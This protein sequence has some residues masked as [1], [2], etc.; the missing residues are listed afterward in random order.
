MGRPTGDSAGFNLDFT[1]SQTRFETKAKEARLRHCA[2][3]WRTLPR[4]ESRPSVL[5]RYS[6]RAR[7]LIND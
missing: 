5:V 7:S 4:A 2:I 6:P 3:T 1:F